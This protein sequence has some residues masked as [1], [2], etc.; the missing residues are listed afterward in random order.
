MGVGSESCSPHPTPSA[1]LAVGGNLTPIPTLCH[2]APYTEAESPPGHSV[3]GETVTGLSGAVTGS[4]GEMGGG[5][6][7]QTGRTC[8]AARAKALGWD[9][10]GQQDSLVGLG[11]RG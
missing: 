5:S 1:L 9:A 7:E 6:R 2:E 3:M 11:L 10:E 4:E 8:G